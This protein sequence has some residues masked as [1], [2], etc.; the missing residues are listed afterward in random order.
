VLRKLVSWTLL[1]WQNQI[2]LS[3]QNHGC[4]LTYT[5]VSSHHLVISWRHSQEG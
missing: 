4:A 3:E 5:T 1:T 2:L